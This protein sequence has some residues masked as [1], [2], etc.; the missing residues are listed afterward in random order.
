[1]VLKHLWENSMVQILERPRSLSDR[2][3]DAFAGAGQAVP[4]IIDTYQKAQA[5]KLE[6][7][8]KISAK[9]EKAMSAYLKDYHKDLY[10][11]KL[12]GEA[13]QKYQDYIYE[14]PD[15]PE[16]ELRQRAVQAVRDERTKGKGQKEGPNN[17]GSRNEY[18]A[19]ENTKGVSFPTQSLFAE[20]NSPLGNLGERLQRGT[21]S[22]GRTVK[23]HPSTL[24]TELPTAASKALDMQSGGVGSLGLMSSGRLR[25]LGFTNP[26]GFETGKPKT[27]TE[28]SKEY[29]R[30]NLPE[31]F[32]EGAENLSDVQAILMD[33]FGKKYATKAILNQL[34]A[35]NP[36][37][38]L[39]PN[40]IGQQAQRTMPPAQL[41]GAA[42]KQLGLQ[43]PQS[44]P[45]PQG[46]H[47]AILE[48][49]KAARMAAQVAPAEKAAADFSPAAQAM[50]EAGLGGRVSQ[51]GKSGTAL[52]MNRVNP[53][54][55]LVPVN[56]IYKTRMDQLKAFPKYDQEIA[57]DAVDR[58]IRRDKLI[59]KTEKG[60]KSLEARIAIAEH[61]LP[62]IQA[63]YTRAASRVRALENEMTKHTGAE[64][65]RS[66]Q[67]YDI[68]K[69]ELKEASNDLENGI[70]N[71]KFGSAKATEAE[72]RAAARAK[73]DE[74]SK[75]V[76][77]GEE[78]KL[79]GHDYSPKMI[80]EAKEISKRKPLPNLKPDDFYNKIHD[81][82]V[83]PY[84]QRVAELTQEIKE[85]KAAG[86]WKGYEN[87]KKEQDII[88][89]MIKSA[90]AEQTIHTHKLALRDIGE[91][92][93]ARDRFSQ[94][95]KVEGKPK[96]A[97]VA[98]EKMWRNQMQN[99]RSEQAR[100][101]VIEEGVQE[102]AAKHPE[103]AQ[104]ILQEGEK[105]KEEVNQIF[106]KIQQP[107]SPPP[108]NPQ[109]QTTRVN[110]TQQAAQPQQP[111]PQAN[112]A[113]QAP[114]SAAGTSP[115]PP[116][117]QPIPTSAFFQNIFSQ[118]GQ[119]MSKYPVIRTFGKDFM[120]GLISGVVDEVA[121]AYIDDD[122]VPHGFIGTIINAVKH[123]GDVRRSA[124]SS[125]GT[126]T[127]KM[128]IKKWKVNRA[129]NQYISDDYN[130]LRKFTQNS[131]QIKNKVYK[132]LGAEG[133][134]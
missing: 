1:M 44:S 37:A 96:V 55:K 91:A 5:K 70:A 23:S 13:L 54:S 115:P 92:K 25:Q 51:P 56:E 77:S 30:K 72:S 39:G 32:H 58:Q 114:P 2:F 103:Q 7:R 52:R 127:A 79:H 48:K 104:A 57:K 38:I 129:Y 33:L 120:F 27:L 69:Q 14:H 100:A 63:D 110:P 19:N 65:E 134:E 73:L 89:K 130:E 113:G 97:S 21:Q 107:Q 125:L 22:I 76:E 112:A 40:Q 98:E 123:A 47:P 121:K 6:G 132:R 42:Y 111:Q 122:D 82:Y 128:A 16:H 84:R 18:S 102:I 119:F 85:A 61:Q 11:N 53:E 59:P 86:D 9:S 68:L 41:Q 31:E 78:Y 15:V 71:A 60:Q 66:K 35:V 131:T 20:S 88:G 126:A 8:H 116:P 50:K 105:L 28:A 74:I 3:S 12:Q 124:Y 133:I 75:V 118:L 64:L 106:R 29:F 87:L 36:S 83:Q 67:L 49:M 24:A 80:S 90:E 46:I 99:A 26:E 4:G 10:G 94:L 95:Q 109:A 81:R 117:A 34:P 93:R 101:Q 43:P 45:S 17:S 62:A 108:L